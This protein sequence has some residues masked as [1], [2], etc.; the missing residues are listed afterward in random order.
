MSLTRQVRFVSR[1][2]N[3]FL[4]VVLLVT[5]VNRQ[6]AL[7]NIYRVLVLVD[8]CFTIKRVLGA[9]KIYTLK[10]I[11]LRLLIAI[12][13]TWCNLDFIVNYNYILLKSIKLYYV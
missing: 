13:Y 9:N 11:K 6:E 4:L 10:E 8:F 5:V 7:R 3:A 2:S 1:A 12:H